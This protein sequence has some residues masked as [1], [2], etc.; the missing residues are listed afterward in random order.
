ME[1][2]LGFIGAGN[3][4]RAIIGGIVKAGLVPGGQIC[5]SNPSQGK[6]EALRQDYG[7]SVT[8][9]N[10]AVAAFARDVL[11]LCVKPGVLPKVVEEIRDQVAAE[12][13]VVSIAAGKSLQSIMDGFGRCLPL[14]R[15]MPNTPALVGAGCSALCGNEE[16]L[17]PERAEQFAAVLRLCES[18][19]TAVQMP[20][21]LIDVAGQVAGASPAWMFMVIEALADGAVA[22]GMPRAMAYQLAAAG[23]MGAGK[24]ALSEG[25]NPGKLK[26]MVTSPGGTT[27]QGVRVLEERAVRGAFMD[28]VIQAVERARGL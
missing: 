21:Q 28:A 8:P 25:G 20:E 19:G 5:V 3:M 18:F 17:R 15:V 26:D 7:V 6:L 23:V 27:I 16:A 24:L 9:D 13:M 4:A 2:K 12:T 10:K 11:F 14:V 1:L 22:E